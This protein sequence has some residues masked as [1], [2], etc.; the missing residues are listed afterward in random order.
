MCFVLIG[1]LCVKVAPAEYPTMHNFFLPMLVM[2]DPRV[3]SIYTTVWSGINANYFMTFD[4]GISFYHP[5]HLLELWILL[6]LHAWPSVVS[7]CNQ[8]YNFWKVGSSGIRDH[9]I[10]F[11][12]YIPCLR[13]ALAEV[14]WDRFCVPR[15][16][17]WL[18]FYHT[19]PFAIA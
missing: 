8:T 19:R 6:F 3:L 10:W 15:A 14:A 13:V 12:S 16:Q 2:K 4:H 7:P 11:I 5:V 9:P 1:Y 17:L 18:H